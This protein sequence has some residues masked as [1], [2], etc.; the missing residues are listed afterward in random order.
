MTP[1]T[2][3]GLVVGGAVGAMARYLLG[4]AIHKRTNGP[5]PLSTFVINVTGSLVL[6]VVTGAVLYSGLANM[7]KIWV[8]TGFCGAFTTFSTFTFESVA[9]VERGAVTVALRYALLSLLVATT[10]AA[11]GLALGAAW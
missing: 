1:T 10:A 11:A 7:V 2:L 3:A 8:G 5:F 4:G 6:G 9:L